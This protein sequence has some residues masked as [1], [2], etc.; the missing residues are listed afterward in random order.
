VPLTQQSG[1]IRVNAF[2]LPS[3]DKIPEVLYHYRVEIRRV[4][5]EDG[6]VDTDD[7]TEKRSNDVIS[8]AVVSSMLLSLGI[9]PARGVTYDGSHLLCST[10]PLSPDDDIQVRTS[11]SSAQPSIEL[12]SSDV[13]DS[14]TVFTD[15]GK[16]VREYTISLP[17]GMSYRLKLLVLANMLRPLSMGKHFLYQLV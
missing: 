17:S 13:D 8:I 9:S 6:T 15:T 7:I 10:F 16:A 2:R 14:S 5:G 12:H 3:I 1:R 4:I 11:S